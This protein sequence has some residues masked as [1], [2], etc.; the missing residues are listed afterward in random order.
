MN[1]PWGGFKELTFDI[2]IV[3]A[4]HHYIG[5]GRLRKFIS[6]THYHD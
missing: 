4:G 1:E 5:F 6:N 3:R 2:L